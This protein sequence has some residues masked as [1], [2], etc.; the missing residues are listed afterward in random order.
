MPHVGDL[1]EQIAL[2]GTR[3]Q[4]QAIFGIG[5]QVFMSVL[6]EL[7]GIF[8][9]WGMSLVSL[10]PLALV[11]VV[12]LDDVVELLDLLTRDLAVPDRFEI[13]QNLAE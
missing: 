5:L 9:T 2:E 13:L 10:P 6:A 8:E 4:N 3:H 12:F 1:G 7:L 11:L